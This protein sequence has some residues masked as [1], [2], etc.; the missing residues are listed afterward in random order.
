M[1]DIQ[2]KV[3]FVCYGGGHSAALLPVIKR[4]ISREV[5]VAVL[6]LTTAKRA[7][8]REGI[9]TLDFSALV[10]GI[11]PYKRAT[12]VGS[13][14]AKAHASHPMVSFRDTAAY[15][16]VGFHALVR[17]YG[18]IKAKEM[19]ALS[20]RQ[21]FLPTDFFIELFKKERPSLVVSTNS[22]RS[23]R[24]ALEA[25]RELGIP[26]VC[27][28]D[29]YAYYEIEWCASDRYASKVCVL[30]QQ[31]CERF[32]DAGLNVSRISI[33]GNPAFDRL[34]HIDRLQCRRMFRQ[35]L[36]IEE[37]QSL[38]VWISQPEPRKHPFSGA[39]GDENYPIGVE[40]YLFEVFGNDPAV[41]LA[42]RLHPSES[43][44]PSVVADRVHYSDSTD[45]LDHLLCAADCIVTASSTVGLEAAYLGLPVI[46]CMDSIFSHDLPLAK[47]GVATAVETYRDLGGAIRSVLDCPEEGR[48][49]NLF[50][51][52]A[53]ARVEAV[54]LE[55]LGG[56]A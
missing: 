42:M 25:A 8:E 46:Q 44:P 15:L 27:L 23:E 56:G 32:V 17:D 16:G 30:N 51:G 10:E 38:V 55:L 24:A 9:K 33:T 5:D 49:P 39:L 22:P 7:I 43:R 29:L 41:H 40:K 53:A 1:S 48:T 34:A 35:R 37:S 26:S 4:L 21:V 18:L 20:G 36:G 12:D 11:R 50:D 54:I 45:S 19:Y 6:G 3:L 47:L 2:D 13:M 14:L 31:V 28:V 52:S